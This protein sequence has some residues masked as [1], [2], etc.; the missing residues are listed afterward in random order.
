M[1]IIILVILVAIVLIISNNCIN[2]KEDFHNIYNGYINPYLQQPI[3]NP[4]LQQ[5]IINQ[6]LQQPIINQYLQQPILFPIYSPY[7][8][9]Y[10]LNYPYIPS[11]F[12]PYYSQYDILNTNGTLLN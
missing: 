12:A 5:P 9:Y 6:Y 1:N 11:M 4:Y 8:R 10:L 7:R 3:I 2:N